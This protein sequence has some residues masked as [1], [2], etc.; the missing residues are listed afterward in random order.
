MTNT[1]VSSPQSFEVSLFTSGKALAS[2]TFFLFLFLGVTFSSHAQITY[3]WNGT[4]STAWDNTAN[5][6]KSSGTSTPGTNASDI[7]VIPATV[8]NQPTLSTA[9]STN[10]AS[11][12][13]S[14]TAAT[15]TITGQTLSVTGAV[16]LNSAAG[17]NTAATITGTGTIS[18][19]SVVVGSTV[20][21]STTSTT[22]LT[23]TISN[24][25]ISGNLGLIAF[26]SG[27]T[28]NN[29]RFFHESG[30]VTVGG[31]I[32][33]SMPN[34][35]N[36]S[37]FTMANGSSQTGTLNLNGATPF[38]LSGTGTNTITLNGTGATVNYSGSAQ[39]V[40][41]TNYTNLILS[42]SGTKTLQTG[43]T[44]IGGNLT[45]SGTATATTVVGLTVSGNL[46]VGDGTTFTAAGFGLTV[47]GT[48]TVG[49]GTSG[50][51]TISSATGTKLF[52]GLVT[53]AT[54][55]T[56]SNSGNSALE[57]RGGITSTPSFT[58]GSGV[59]TF[60]T[61][62]QALSGTFTIPSVTVTGV[63]LT[64]N[65]SLTVNTALSGTGGITQA[66]NATLNIGGT[67]GI[68]TLTATAS[69]NTVNYSGAAQTVY[70]GNYSN[71]TL[72]GSGAK[73]LQSGT[74][75]IGGNLTLSGTATAT[76]V[77]GL[78][79]SGNL[80][81]GD[82]TTFT[83]AGFGLTVT[84]TTTVGGGASGNLTI[85]S[86]TGTKL[87]TGLVTIGT[88]ATWSNSGNSALEFRGGITTTPS[89]TGGTGVHT[90]TTNA[91]SLTG[92]F[93]IPSVT[94]TGIALTNNSTLTTNTALAGTGSITQAASATLNIGGT[95]SLA[96]IT[97]SNTGNTVNYTGSSQNIIPGTYLN[98]TINQSSGNAS[99]TGATTVNNQLTLTAGK[100]VTSTN[101]LTMGSSAAD[102][103]GATTAKYVQG[104]LQ[105]IM[106]AGTSTKKF[107]IGSSSAYAP[108]TLAM[109][110]VSGQVDV[111][112]AA[113]AGDVPGENSP[114]TNASGIDQT[115]KVNHYWSITK[116]GAGTFSAIPTFD[117]SNT[118]NNGTVA[119]YKLRK[120][121]P[122]PVYWTAPASTVSGTTISTT[123]GLTSFSD[124][125][126]GE[127]P[128]PTVSTQPS[129]AAV[130]L[131]GTATFTIVASGAPAVTYQWRKDG[132]ALTNG[133]R[134]SGATTASL[135]ITNADATDVA[136][137]AAG[138]DCVITN[139][140][141]TATSSRVALSLNA[142]TAITSNPSAASITYGSNTSFVVSASAPAR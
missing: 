83:A 78:T 101:V 100:L 111:T 32:T 115:K 31:S 12:T 54:G 108:V 9:L 130:C 14:G 140:N 134:I 64:N 26:R 70:A 61:N 4:T 121:D 90:F 47:T 109:S 120:Y 33:T 87:F 128:A 97:A 41:A 29:P 45:L 99:L 107:E 23:S 89:F 118:T 7:V 5:W 67:S 44:T 72:S 8:T 110:S 24:L 114:T 80:S 48:T 106:P 104:N 133:G 21:P 127:A 141:G 34:S 79:V 51:L 50:N 20:T 122:D 142:A 92:T 132:V 66:S 105:W 38:S 68:T 52:T 60:S 96:S 86:S 125:Q 53:V 27:T 139:I 129:A 63:T 74:T 3:T 1:T 35:N 95:A 13:F 75:T 65:N 57:F 30:T 103:A 69:G 6:T 85:S 16:T 112:A 98:L 113:I 56:W 71:L 84:G 73:T 11:L 88:G 119:N 82:G 49:G 59:H 77:V 81:V 137:A 94:V 102:I 39:T 116:S 117:F 124:F 58:G 28:Y 126:V 76:T 25:T 91:Q 40:F 131:G 62:A 43:T 22:I 15:L 18:C 138:Y 55:A 42:G 123:S 93:T 19:A 37:I 17:S 46:S 135:A 10:I 136:L 2:I 36:S